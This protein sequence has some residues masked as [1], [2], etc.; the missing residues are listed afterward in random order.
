RAPAPARP[1]AEEVGA[2]PGKLRIGL[3]THNP[4]ATGEIHADCVAA[5]RE[6]AELL[7]SLGHTVEE[8]FPAALVDGALVNHFTVLWAANLVYTIRYWERKV[9]R[10]VTATFVPF[11]PLGNMT[12]QPAISLPLSWNADGLPIG[13]HLQA[14]YGR[15]DV[16]LRVASQLEQARPWA[17]RIPS[18]HV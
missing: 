7:E 6:T 9:G 13:S 2:S 5:A 18:V 16:L 1:Y 11:T 3:L 17:D 12:G 8:T 15:E 14:A 10:E 4:L